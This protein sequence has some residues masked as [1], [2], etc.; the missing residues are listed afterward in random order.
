MEL[1]VKKVWSKFKGI[2]LKAVKPDHIIMVVFFFNVYTESEVRLHTSA[3]GLKTLVY[4]VSLTH[5]C[6]DSFVLLFFF[7]NESFLSLSLSLSHHVCCHPS[8]CKYASTRHAS[9]MSGPSALGLRLGLKQTDLK[10]QPRE[11]QD[12]LTPLLYGLFMKNTAVML[13]VLSWLLKGTFQAA[14]ER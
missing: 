9:G 4:N 11:F 5:I 8:H 14:G 10:P 12:R 1:W 3:P 6:F 2:L 7:N 13:T